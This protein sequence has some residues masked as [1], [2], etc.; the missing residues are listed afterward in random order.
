MAQPH[1][2]SKF[3]AAISATRRASQQTITD[4][5]PSGLLLLPQAPR[6]PCRSARH[7]A[8]V[9]E[10]TASKTAASV[11]TAHSSLAETSATASPQTSGPTD[12]SP[13]AGSKTATNVFI[14]AFPA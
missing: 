7:R 1:S 2:R 14:S 9:F 11:S 8:R 6:R 5:V 3:E 12:S 10:G 4:L 13:V